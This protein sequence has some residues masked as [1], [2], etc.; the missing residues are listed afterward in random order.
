MRKYIDVAG[1]PGADHVFLVDGSGSRHIDASTE[2]LTYFA[3]FQADVRARSQTA[4]PRG[5]ALRVT[6]LAIEAQERARRL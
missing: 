4:M 3:R 6:R 5:H 1:R 2:A